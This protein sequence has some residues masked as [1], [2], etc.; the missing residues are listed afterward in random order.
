M[1]YLQGSADA[2]LVFRVPPLSGA[3]RTLPVSVFSVQYRVFPLGVFIEERHNVWPNVAMYVDNETALNAF[4]KGCSDKMLHLHKMQKISLKW[5]NEVSKDGLS[6]FLHVKSKDNLADGLTKNLAVD[7]FQKQRHG[8]GGKLLLLYLQTEDDGLISL[9]RGSRFLPAQS[10]AEDCASQAP[11]VTL[12]TI[13]GASFI[14]IFQAW[15]V[16]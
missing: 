8:W 16:Q 4:K 9:P 3:G 15:F 6:D 10:A 1:R 7:S 5:L 13:A 2:V 11:I 12:S 14:G